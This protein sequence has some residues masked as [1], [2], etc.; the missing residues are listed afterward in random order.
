MTLQERRELIAQMSKAIFQYCLSR[1]GS[2]QESEDLSQEIM[3]TLCE[4]IENLRSEKAFYGFVWRTADNILKQWYRGRDKHTT[5]RLDESVSDGSWEAREEQSEL[6]EQLYLLTREL[7]LLNS[8][9]RRVMVAYYIDGL[10]VGDISA[11]FSLSP[12]MV[13]YLLF[14]SRKRIKEGILMERN[15]GEYSYNPVKLDLRLLNAPVMDYKG[16]RKSSIQQNILMACYYDKQNEE[17]L[18]LQLG[19]PTAYLEDEIRNLAEYELICEKNGFYLSNV[20]ISTKRAMDERFRAK[21]EALKKAADRFESFFEE[22]EQRIRAIGF[23]GSDMPVNSLKWL[24]LSRAARSYFDKLCELDKELPDPVSCPSA[25]L[26]FVEQEEAPKGD[27][28]DPLM[29]RW[30]S[31]FGSIIFYRVRFNSPVFIRFSDVEENVL[32]ELPTHQPET[33]NDKTVCAELMDKGY[34]VRVGN[35]I[36]PNLPCFTEKQF[37]ELNDLME[38]LSAELFE[39]A[40]DRVEMTRRMT[41]D[42]TPERFRQYVRDIVSLS[43]G[44]EISCITRLLAE[45]SRLIPWTGMN[46]TDIIV[47]K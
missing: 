38:P 41:L 20:M 26:F 10:S 31:E 34:A 13:K 33:E 43:M 23:Y 7:S 9:Y 28:F 42:H 37:R 19:V 22:N 6:N 29:G 14:Q 47:T 4:S 30:D 45:D 39:E 25:R 12:S 40:A 36:K 1:T 27:N 8:N 18:S 16:F 15:Y 5:A 21:S 44:E 35:E 46:A 17:Q 2:Y 24:A 11:R 3:L 32:T